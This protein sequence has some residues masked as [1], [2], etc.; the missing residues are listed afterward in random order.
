[1][2]HIL[3]STSHSEQRVK[4]TIKRYIELRGIIAILDL[5]ELSKED[6]LTIARAQKIERFLSQPFFIAEVFI[7]SSGKYVGLAETIKGFKLILS[8]ELDSIPKQAFYLVGNINE[9]TAKA[10]NLEM[11]NKLKK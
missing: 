1:M 5:D 3:A 2:V 9:A 7:G 11:E 10:T 4:Q 6:C 8:R